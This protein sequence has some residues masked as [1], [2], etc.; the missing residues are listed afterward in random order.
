[1]SIRARMGAQLMAEAL[2]GCPIV[3]QLSVMDDSG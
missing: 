3:P 2:C 1:M